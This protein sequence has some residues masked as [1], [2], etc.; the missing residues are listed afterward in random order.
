[1]KRRH[2]QCFSLTVAMAV[3]CVSL[4]CLTS[5]VSRTYAADTELTRKGTGT[6]GWHAT[7]Y[8]GGFT[9]DR[10]V[11]NTEWIANNMKDF[12][13]EYICLDGWINDGTDHN[14]NGYVVRYKKWIHDFAYWANYVHAKGLKFGVYYNPTW[15][16]K[17]IADDPNVKI[18]GTDIPLKSIVHPDDPSK[19]F[20][21]WYM[22]DPSLPGAE[23]YIKGMVDYYKSAG[24]DLLKVDFIR[25]FDDAYGPEA[26][27]TFYKWMRE[28]AGDDIILYYA[29]QKNRDHAAAESEY[30]DMIR[31]SEDYRQDI[32]FHNSVRNRGQVKDNSWPP[33]YNLFDGL[34]WLS[35]KSGKGKAILDGD[36]SVLSSSTSDSEKKFRLSLLAMAGSSLNIGDN[37]SNVGNNDVYYQNWEIINMNQAGFIGK[38]L[39]RDVN[40]PLSQI[41]KGQMPDGSWV[42]GLFNREDTVQTRSIDFAKDLGL[43]GNYLVSDMWT[44]APLGS[45]S[46]YSADI[47]AHGVRLIKISQLAMEPSGAF[48]HRS[49]KVTLHGL[50]PK[51]KIHYTTDGSEPDASSPEYKGSIKID[52]TT[53]L[54]AKIIQGDGRGYEAAARFIKTDTDPIDKIAANIQSIPAPDKG[55]EAIIMPAVPYGYTVDLK[56][57]DREDVITRKGSIITPKVD[58]RVELV[59]EVKRKSE[60][61]KR[62]I[63]VPVNV[64]GSA[65]TPGI[66]IEGES[67]QNS[68]SGPTM[69]TL[70]DTYASQGKFLQTKSA[71]AVNDWVELTVHVAQ[72]GT[73]RMALGYKTYGNMGTAQLFVDGKPQGNPVDQYASAQIITSADLGDVTFSEPGDHRL[74]FVV[75]GKNAGSTGYHLGFDYIKLTNSSMPPVTTSQ[76]DQSGK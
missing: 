59:F 53:T 50:D 22:V 46:S 74:R 60:G 43:T 40:D 66:V 5:P 75:T 20:Q 54:R 71:P 6:M 26:T 9:E 24:A 19:S 23:Q 16:L 25:L 52:K 48:F 63:R 62:E 7:N 31:A 33:A 11:A 64:R 49:Q 12:G 68:T 65:N 37:Y 8:G 34:V 41:W 32:W 39:V 57:S 14:E 45:M 1:M 58:T 73:Y 35:D 21:D 17:S 67:M 38:P 61:G 70:T 47:E 27:T 30:A 44:H 51:A 36:F 10:M 13:Y 56:S 72:A 29:N 2:R 15:V 18:V 76:A 55:A 42:V 69:T 4:F 28:A 3:S